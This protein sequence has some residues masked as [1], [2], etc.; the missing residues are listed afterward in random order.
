M[1]TAV[2]ARLWTAP[3]PPTGRRL[4][5][6]TAAVSVP[7]SGETVCGDAWAEEQEGSRAAS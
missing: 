2:V 4:R 3:R 6:R 5:F 1:G 7:K